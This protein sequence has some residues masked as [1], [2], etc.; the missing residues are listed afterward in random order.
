MGQR[1]VRFK[2]LGGCYGQLGFRLSIAGEGAHDSVMSN[3]A[4]PHSIEIIFYSAA[5]FLAVVG[6]TWFFLR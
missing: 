6:L 4:P 1:C 2:A 5:S 3:Q